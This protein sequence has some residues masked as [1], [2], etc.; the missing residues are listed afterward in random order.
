MIKMTKMVTEV[1]DVIKDL[2]DLTPN[3]QAKYIAYIEREGQP[4]LR[5][6]IMP[7]AMDGTYIIEDKKTGERERREYSRSDYI[8]RIY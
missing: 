6:D 8:E 1:R 5:V 7:Y 4:E 2:F 3:W